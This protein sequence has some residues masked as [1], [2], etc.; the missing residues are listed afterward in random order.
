MVSI[1]K[2]A[3]WLMILLAEKFKIR[4]LLR[5]SGCFHSL[6]QARG[7]GMCSD[8]MAREEA[9]EALFDNQLSWELIE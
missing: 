2:S 6:R 7:A 1:E 5:A 3:I 4:H 9:R 8:L